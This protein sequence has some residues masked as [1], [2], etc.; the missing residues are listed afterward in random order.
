MVAQVQAVIAR[1][2]VDAIVFLIMGAHQQFAAAG[3]LPEQ[4]E[5]QPE[6]VAHAA[7]ICRASRIVESGVTRQVPPGET[8]AEAVVQRGPIGAAKVHAVEIAITGANIACLVR[9]RSCGDEID[10]PARSVAAIERALRAFQ[11]LDPVEVI[12]HQAGLHIGRQIDAVG[13]DRCSRR[14]QRLMVDGADAADLEGD[15]RA[16]GHRRVD[17]G[18]QVGNVFCPEEGIRE[19]ERIGLDYADGHRNVGQWRRAGCGGRDNRVQAPRRVAC[20]SESR[21]GK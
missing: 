21:G 2:G 13:I 17:A 7:R 5:A 1:R 8:I 9:A 15:L 16:V 4:A 12:Q 14:R 20:F 10:R 3:M 19:A 18:E 11:D 6:L